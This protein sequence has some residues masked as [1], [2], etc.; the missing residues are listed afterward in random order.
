MRATFGTLNGGLRLVLARSP[1]T[2]VL[3]PA[4]GT[5]TTTADAVAVWGGSTAV[6]SN[7][8]QL[9]RAA[10]YEVVTTASPKNFEYVRSLGATTVFDYKQ[11]DTTQKIIDALQGK[12]CAG[13]LAIGIGSL[14]ACIDI[15]AAVPGRKFV[16]QASSPVDMNDMPKSIFGFAGCIGIMWWNFSVALKA[17]LKGVSTKFIW[18]S[19][20]MANELGPMI[21]QDFLPGAL[22]DNQFQAKPEPIAVGNSL[23]SLQ[24]G[25]DVCQKGLLLL[26]LL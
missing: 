11:P 20:V 2:P 14:E 19:D 9:A 18:G 15:V 12:N 1:R 8:I 5:T 17:R 25:I 7:A 22:A 24:R 10:G 26:K 4:A 23:E 21:Y 16:S 6:G 13:A 3:Q